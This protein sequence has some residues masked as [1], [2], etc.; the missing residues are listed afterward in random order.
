MRVDGRHLALAAG[1]LPGQ[2]LRPLVHGCLLRRQALYVLAMLAARG[3]AHEDLQRLV[4]AF[5]EQ[6][7]TRPVDGAGAED[8]GATGIQAQAQARHR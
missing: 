7:G 2:A 1:Q 8:I 3:E 5:T 6:G 4:A